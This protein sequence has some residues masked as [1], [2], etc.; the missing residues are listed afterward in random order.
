MKMKGVDNKDNYK[1]TN[2]RQT[3]T[4]KHGDKNTHKLAFICVSVK[5]R[6]SLFG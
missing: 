4:K 6:Y 3:L 1:N 5:E 2:K